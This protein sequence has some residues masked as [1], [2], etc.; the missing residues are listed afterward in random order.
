[1]LRSTMF[2][3]VLNS[4]ICVSSGTQEWFIDPEL[5]EKA[6]IVFGKSLKP[7][8]QIGNPPPRIAEV[9]KSDIISC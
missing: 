1:M 5:A 9:R 2:G 4:P 3:R 7:K 8:P 6:G